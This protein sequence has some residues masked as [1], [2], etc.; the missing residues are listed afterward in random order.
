VE[1]H[2]RLALELTESVLVLERGRIVH[3]GASSA[4]VRDTE[5]QRKLLAL[6]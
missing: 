1:Q 2:A 3:R 4:L 5:L 6:P